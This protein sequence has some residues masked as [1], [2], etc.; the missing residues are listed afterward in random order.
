[1]ELIDGSVAVITGAASG[2]G[3]ELGRAFA[4]A[5]CSVVLADVEATPLDAVAAGIDG[6]VL[7]VV[8]DVCSPDALEHLADAA[9]DRFGAVHVVCNNA[10]VSTFNP[11]AA[12]TLDDWRWV[13]GVNLW[14][15]VHGVQAFPPGCWPRGCPPVSSTRHRW[16]VWRADCRHSAPTTSAKSEWSPSAR[17]CAWSWPWPAR[18]SG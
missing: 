10:G 5:G 13:L 1:M 9:F 14:G 16:L 12:Q 4:H 17:P 8:T 3:T 6:E 2:I 7:T 15:V 11:I 18:Q